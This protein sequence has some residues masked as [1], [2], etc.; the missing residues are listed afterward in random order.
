MPIQSDVGSWTLTSILS[1]RSH[2]KILVISGVILASAYLCP[3]ISV[4]TLVGACLAVFV[5]ILAKRPL[6]GLFVL[7]PVTLI[8]PFSVST[9]TLTRLSG[10]VLLLGLLV[11]IWLLMLVRQLLARGAGPLLRV[12]P[13]WALLVFS[14]TAALSFIFGTQRWLVFAQTAPLN[15]QLGGLAIFLLSAGAFLIAAHWVCDEQSLRWLTWLFLGCGSLYVVA[16]LLSQS[17]GLEASFPVGATDSLFWVW[18]VAL[19][20]SQALL[21]ERLAPQFR[22]ALLGLT[23]A[24]LWL[25]WFQGRQWVSGWLPPLVAVLVIVWL[26]SWRVGLLI[27]IV[28][29]VYLVWRDPGLADSLFNLKDYSIYTRNEARQILLTQ[30]LPI[31]PVL[32]LGPAN[33]YWYTPLFPILGYYVQF[34]SHN[35]YVDILLQTGILGLAC[36]VWFVVEVGRLGWRLRTRVPAGFQQAY[37]YGALGG[38]AGTLVSA[39]LGDWFLPFVYNVGFSGFRASMLAWVFLGALVAIERMRCSSLSASAPHGSL[40]R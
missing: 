33:Y 4:Q 16:R 13:V 6:V 25:G 23:T 24:M 8:L 15:S 28:G 27:T 26:R 36:F 39:W 20:F 22:L 38:L 9:G 21:N 34:N 37:V 32:G 14:A 18:A 19:A 3:R 5:L 29:A 40:R 30:V 31:S 2:L 11:A 35:N 12:G 7:V 1:G 10:G 17:F